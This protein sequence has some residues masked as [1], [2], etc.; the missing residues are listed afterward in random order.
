VSIAWLVPAAFA[1]LALV[2][3]PIV[4]HLLVRQHSRQAPFPSLRFLQSSR[5]SALKR[6][7][8]H[9]APLLVCRVLI[10]VAAVAALAAPVVDS[11]ARRAGFAKRLARA[12]VIGEGVDA[13]AVEGEAVGAFTSAVFSRAQMSDGIADA[14]RWL[15]A[16]PPASRELVV[17]GPFRR[18]QLHRSDFAVVPGDIGIRAMPAA[19]GEKSVDLVFPVIRLRD[20]GA[21]RVMRRVHVDVDS[22][23]VV[24]GVV[25]PLPSLPIRVI[26][27]PEE[28]ALADAALAAALTSGVRWPEDTSARQL[29]LVWPG[30][31]ES[32]IPQRP[33]GASVVRLP[34]VAE[35]GQAASVVARA[36]VEAVAAPTG[37]LEPFVIPADDLA[38]WSRPPGPPPAASTPADEGDRRWL[39]GVALMLMGVEYLLRRLPN[40]RAASTAG[41]SVEEARVA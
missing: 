14:V 38:Q 3:V 41:G 25:A 6:R 17:V 31:P 2:A 30:T 16:Q 20:G 35:E 13:T 29:V 8:I 24:D 40:S 9:D 15:E 21:A 37:A 23:T 7:S 11:A 22:T 33:A 10:I 1:G 12:V 5:L 34:G 39:W 28:Q 32:L 4:V 26:A 36:I 18:G 27:A 19:R